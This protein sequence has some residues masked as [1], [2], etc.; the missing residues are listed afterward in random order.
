MKLLDRVKKSDDTDDPMNRSDA[1]RGLG[2][3]DDLEAAQI[4]ANKDEPYETIRG[5]RLKYQKKKDEYEQWVRG[6]EKITGAD[7][8]TKTAE[9]TQAIIAEE[10]PTMI[11]RAF[12]YLG[13]LGTPFGAQLRALRK[14]AK[15][16]GEP[17]EKK[18]LTSEIAS[19][20]LNLAGGDRKKAEQLAKDDGYEW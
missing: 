3:F 14:G 1:K 9:M 7:I 18:V 8:Q 6:Q 19:Q 5:I 10:I 11:E 20:Y 15:P 2:V 4:S 17:A 13:T 12:G 16:K